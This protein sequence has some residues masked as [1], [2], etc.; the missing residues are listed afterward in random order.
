M[1]MTQKIKASL[2]MKIVVGLKNENEPKNEENLKKEGEDKRFFC[3]LSYPSQGY[4][5]Q[6]QF[7]YCHLYLADIFISYFVSHDN[8][9]S[10]LPRSNPPLKSAGDFP[11]IDRYYQIE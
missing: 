10:I 3:K 4:H 6:L 8:I 5:A 7:L 1:K 11:Q 2:K 9:W